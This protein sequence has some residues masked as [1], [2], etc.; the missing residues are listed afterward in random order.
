M[1]TERRKYVRINKIL[2]VSYQVVKTLMRPGAMSRDIS[3]GGI[4]LVLSQNLKCGDVLDIEIFIIEGEPPMKALGVVVWTKVRESRQDPFEVGIEFT[5][6]D[7]LDRLRLFN[8]LRKEYNKH[9]TG[10]IEWLG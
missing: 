10:K 6:I 3:K 5:K 7:P 4:R 8:Y 2:V 9:K 1:T